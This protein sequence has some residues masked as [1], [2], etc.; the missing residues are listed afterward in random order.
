M[1]RA[2]NISGQ[3]YGR[4]VARS[5]TGKRD[6]SGC[7]IWL[8]DCDCGAMFEAAGKELRRGHTT[9]CGCGRKARAAKGIRVTHEQTRGGS[10]TPE[11]RSWRSMITRCSNPR[12]HAWHRYGGRGIEVCQRWRA[13]FLHFVADMGR[14]PP[15]TSLDRFPDPDGNYEPGNCRWATRAQQRQNRGGA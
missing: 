12:Y 14:R 11:Y 7:A 13:S 8:C 4:L 2:L 10:P 3:R 5:D 15:G 9:S 6:R 1:S